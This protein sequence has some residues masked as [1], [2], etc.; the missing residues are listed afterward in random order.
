MSRRFTING[1]SYVAS[2]ITFNSI[3][4]LEDAGISLSDIEKKPIST[5]RAYLAVCGNIDNATAGNEI[6]A[7]LISGG[8]LDEIMAVFR[9]ELSDSDFFQALNKTEE[10]ETTE[11]E[12]AEA[13]KRGRKK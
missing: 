11:D 8:S 4:E 9:D 12:T 13:P 6:Q 3:C 2:E 5:V 7:H 10:A 1:K